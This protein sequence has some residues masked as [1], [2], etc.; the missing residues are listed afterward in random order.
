MSGGYVKGERLRHW[1]GECHKARQEHLRRNRDYKA[2]VLAHPDIA[3]RLTEP[4]M[5]YTRPDQWSGYIPPQ[6]IAGAGDNPAEGRL[7]TSPYR[8]QLVDIM[9]EL[10]QRERQQAVDD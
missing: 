4:P 5:R 2:R 7:N 8:A 6:W 1:L 10:V 9:T 3:A